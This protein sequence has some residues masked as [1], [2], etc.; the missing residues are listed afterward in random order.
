MAPEVILR[1][2]YGHGVDW[3]SLGILLYKMLTGSLPYV[4]RTTKEILD[5]IINRKYNWISLL[6]YKVIKNILHVLYSSLPIN[7]A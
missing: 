3:W 1:H 2:L 5:E 6:S 7:L 4:S